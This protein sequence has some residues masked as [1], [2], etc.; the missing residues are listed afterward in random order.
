M[1]DIKVEE[2]EGRAMIAWTK[3]NAWRDWASL[4]EGTAVFKFSYRGDDYTE[5]KIRIWK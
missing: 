2:H 5:A 3:R 1:F 4:L